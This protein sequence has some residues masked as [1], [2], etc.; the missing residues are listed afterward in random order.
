VSS[1][2]ACSWEEFVAAYKGEGNRE[3]GVCVHTRVC[4]RE[5][6]RARARERESVCES[7]WMFRRVS[8]KERECTGGNLSRIMY[9][10]SWA[11]RVNKYICMCV[12]I[13]IYAYT[14]IYI[15]INIYILYIHIFIYIHIYT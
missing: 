14:C 7:A 9:A 10:A 3:V 8:E 13:Y 1:W 11:N 15:Y 5:R 2:F 4:V 12:Y 6:E